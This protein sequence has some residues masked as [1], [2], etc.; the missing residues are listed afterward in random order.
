MLLIK[1]GREDLVRSGR[2]EDGFRLETFLGVLTL[3]LGAPP[4]IIPPRLPINPLRSN[5]DLT[6]V[7]T[8][9]RNSLRIGPGERAREKCPPL[10]FHFEYTRKSFWSRP[11][12]HLS[13]PFLH[14]NRRIVRAEL[15]KKMK[16]PQ[17]GL[18][19][20]R[21][22]KSK[23]IET[24]SSSEEEKKFF[25]HS[26]NLSFRQFSTPRAFSYAICA[27]VSNRCYKF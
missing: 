16:N 1:G 20:P 24:L 14:K 3:R 10:H 11:R 13:D 17:Q 22:K 26:L 25:G 21:T 7:R 5:K 8:R 6:P 15:L 23:S 27:N 9:N 12:I 4:L 19:Q 2:N 18:F